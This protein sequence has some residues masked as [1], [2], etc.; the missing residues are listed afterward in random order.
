MNSIFKKWWF[1][2]LMIVG[3]LFLIG[4]NN[5]PTPSSHQTSLS[6]QNIASSGNQELE[7]QKQKSTQ[8]EII[9]QESNQGEE[10]VGQDTQVQ[11]FLVTRVI[12]GD[13]IEIEGGQRIRYIGIDTP[14]S[15]YPA[16]EIECYG[17]EASD[18]N[19]KLVENKRVR[20]EKDVSETDRYGRLLRYVWVGDI[21]VNDYLVRQGFANVY[22]YPPDVKYS[23]QFVEAQQEARENNRGL[24]SGCATESPAEPP[25]STPGNIICSTNTYNCSDFATH[26]EAQNVFEK[27]GGVN[28][29]VHKLD[30]DSDGIACESL[31]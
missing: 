18:K 20:L 8:P 16:T 21:F 11:T 4:S 26:A 2:S 5:A 23:N 12:D 10:S 19:K 15:V 7:N 29:D 25:A 30:N 31:P 17:R 24:W 13:T 6:E 1:W 28:N 14:E 9:D 3:I 22:T 27:C